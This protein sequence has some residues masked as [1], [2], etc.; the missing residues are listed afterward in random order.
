MERGEKGM[1]I[2]FKLE[3]E[4]DIDDDEQVNCSW[5][6]LRRWRRELRG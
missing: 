6:F 3:L 1:A 2:L 5:F 4:V